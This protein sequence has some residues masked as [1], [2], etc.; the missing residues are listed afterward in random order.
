MTTAGA[1]LQ[2]G[3][4]VWLATVLHT[5]GSAPR[6]IG[7]MATINEQGQVAGSVP[8]DV[9]AAQ[10]VDAR[11]AVFTL[12]H[13]PKLD[14]LALMEAL[15]MPAL[16]VGVMGSVRTTAARKQRLKLFELADAQLARR[17]GPVG[18]TIGART[19]PEIAIAADLVTALRAV[20]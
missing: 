20:S 6:P 11:T 1:W 15:R 19:P 16:Y 5:Y 14:G 2:R 3:L 12:S 8:D 10:L 13:D 4:R 17:H 9:L 7:S 18:A